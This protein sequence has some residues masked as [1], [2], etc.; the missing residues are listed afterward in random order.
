MDGPAQG[1]LAVVSL[2]VD[3]SGIRLRVTHQR[4]LDLFPDLAS[5]DRRSDLDLLVDALHA[6]EKA[7]RLVSRLALELVGNLAGEREGAIVGRDRNS[8][9]RYRRVPAQGV[10]RC[11]GQVRI[12]P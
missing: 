7:H 4:L 2:H 12:G 1:D 9:V 5:P 11:S 6:N 3:I 10:L 8:L